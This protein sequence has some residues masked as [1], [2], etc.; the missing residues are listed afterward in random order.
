MIPDYDKPIFYYTL[1]DLSKAVWFYCILYVVWACILF[2]AQNFL[3]INLDDSD[4]DAWHRSGVSVVT[5]YK[6]G[7]QY[8][9]TPEGFLTPRLGVK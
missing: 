7:Q 1:K 4:K 2:L 3:A 8:L 5:D 6:T 9:K